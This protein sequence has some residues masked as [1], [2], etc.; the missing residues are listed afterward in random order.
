MSSAFRDNQRK[1]KGVGRIAARVME[2]LDA[3]EPL[4]MRSLIDIC[5]AAVGSD[6]LNQRELRA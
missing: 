5:P 4:T 6:Q 2:Q 1:T 3:R